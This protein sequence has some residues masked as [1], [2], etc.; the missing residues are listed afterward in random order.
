MTRR[1]AA[2]C[3]LLLLLTTLAACTGQDVAPRPTRDVPTLM[4]IATLPADPA[5]PP[6]DTGWRDAEAGVELRRITATPPDER[7]PFP[8]IVARL[9]PGRVR[10]RV[11][12]DPQQPRVLSDWFAERR[13]VLAVNG[14]F[15]TETYAPTALLISDGVASGASYE[16]FGG[17]L[18]VGPDGQVSLWALRDAPYD[19]GTPI[20]QAVQSFP[21]LVFPGGQPAPVDDDGQRARRTAVAID[22]DG[23]VLFVVS[24]TSSFTL[25]ELA[26][27]LAGADLDVDRALNLDG[28]SSTGLF[29]GAGPVSAQIDSFGPLPIVIMAE[30]RE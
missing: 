25:R 23:R 6:A 30:P 17:M 28:G 27:W 29:L 8:V 12:Y 13:P 20:T 26:E 10:L 15:F 24:P 22:R 7:E 9:D 21:M 2:L 11:A 4:P 16:G 5:D 14:G 19:P 18:A 3:P 1:R